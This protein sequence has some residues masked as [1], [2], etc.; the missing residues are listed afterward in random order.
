MLALCRL[1]SIARLLTSACCCSRRRRAPRRLAALRPRQIQEQGVLRSLDPDSESETE[2]IHDPCDAVRVGIAL[3]RKQQALSSEDCQDRAA[4]EGARLLEEDQ[5]L[6]DLG[7]SDTARLCS[8][9]SQLSMLSCQG[10]KCSVVSC[11]SSVRDVRRGAPFCKRHLAEAA[12]RVD[13][14]LPTRL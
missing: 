11:Y 7:G 12:P 6:S 10:R 14:S 2:V 1:H 9:H 4:P 8:H 13:P 5:A 3:H